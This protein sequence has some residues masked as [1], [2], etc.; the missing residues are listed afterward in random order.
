VERGAENYKTRKMQVVDTCVHRK[1][2]E[3][4]AMDAIRGTV[5][6]A[7]CDARLD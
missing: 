5:Q 2:R 1:P 6:K 7:S 4:W 3:R